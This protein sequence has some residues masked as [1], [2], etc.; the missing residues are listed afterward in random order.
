MR[1]VYWKCRCWTDDDCYSIRALTREDALAERNDRIRPTHY[2]DPFRVEVEY[3]S[4]FDL[5]MLCLSSEG[6]PAEEAKAEIDS[7]VKSPDFQY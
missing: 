2:S 6:G 3:G 4:A 1:L 5:L 7:G